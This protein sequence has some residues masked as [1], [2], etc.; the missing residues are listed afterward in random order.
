MKC[1]CFSGQYIC[2]SE[3]GRSWPKEL[4]RFKDFNPKVLYIFFK[5]TEE[6]N[7]I[8]PFLDALVCNDHMSEWRDYLTRSKR[9]FEAKKKTQLEPEYY[10]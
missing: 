6:E 3:T 10:I 5:D 4:D 9:S 7:N 1:T 2:G 8:I